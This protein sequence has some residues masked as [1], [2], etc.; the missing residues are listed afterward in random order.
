VNQPKRHQKHETTAQSQTATE[1]KAATKAP[2]DPLRDQGG[3]MP[4][5]ETQTDKANS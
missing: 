5:M 1:Y 4:Q 2:H 3:T